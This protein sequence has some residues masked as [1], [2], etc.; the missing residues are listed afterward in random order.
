M[1]YL[2]LSTGPVAPQVDSQ[3]CAFAFSLCIVHDKKLYACA[4]ACV[5]ELCL[6]GKLCWQSA[7]YVHDVVAVLYGLS[8]DAALLATSFACH[9]LGFAMAAM[10]VS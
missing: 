1:L 10:Y 6:L 7:S 2:V 8:Q 9:R 4:A 5:S 3:G